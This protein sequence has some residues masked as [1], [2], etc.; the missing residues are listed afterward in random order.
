M[1]NRSRDPKDHLGFLNL[2]ATESHLKG[3]FPMWSREEILSEAY[4]QAHR[5]L[6]TVYEPEKSTVVTF[7]K[8]FL[9]GA[10]HYSYWT[11]NGFRFTDDGPRLKLHVTTDT[12]CEDITVQGPSLSL[13]FP[14]LSEE[15]WTIV[16]LRIHGYTMSQI[17]GVLGLK[18]PQSV[19]NRLVKVRDKF[20]ETGAIDA[21]RDPARSHADRPR[22]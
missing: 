9:W 22:P 16:R 1:V 13:V 2:W 3:R 4:V 6:A 5:L 19:Y 7:L 14:E 11:S 17:A 18:S 21:P 12:L 8:G 10:V 15:E 20:I